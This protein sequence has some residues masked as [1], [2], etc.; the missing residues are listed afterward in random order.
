M[1]LSN[2]LY[3][4]IF[5]GV[6]VLL[7]ML[8]EFNTQQCLESTDNG[9]IKVCVEDS[10]TQITYTGHYSDYKTVTVKAMADSLHESSN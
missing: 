5:V 3:P 2:L 8:P 9:Y 7:L 4:I 1:R 10:T 6:L